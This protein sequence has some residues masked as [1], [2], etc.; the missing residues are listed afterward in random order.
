MSATILNPEA[1]CRNVGLGPS[2]VKF[3]QIQSDFPIE[4][5]LSKAECIILLQNH[6][7]NQYSFW[8]LLL[9]QP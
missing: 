8:L 1:Y 9:L 7:Q 6:I 2:E 3:I 4:K 5:Y